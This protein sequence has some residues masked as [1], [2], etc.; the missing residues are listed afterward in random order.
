MKRIQ[1]FEASRHTRRA[2]EARKRKRG[3]AMISALILLSAL[4]MFGLSMLSASVGGSKVVTTQSDDHRLTS[5]VESVGALAAQDVWAGYVRAQGGAAGNIESLRTYL[6]S[7]GLDPDTNAG[8][9]AAG[10]GSEWL[11][12]LSIPT[13]AAGASVF[14]GVTIDGVRV[15]RRDETDAT[16]LYVTVQATT[17]RGQGLATPAFARS[18]Q[19]VYTVEPAPFEGF[20]YGI[21]ANNVNCVFCHTVIDSAE[22]VWS[23]DP[24]Q[25]DTFH[26]VK[27]G[28]LESLM[29]RHDG[30]PAIGDWDSDTRIAGSL[31]VRGNATNQN[32]VPIS[33][34]AS[35]SSKPCTFDAAGNIVQ[36]DY[37]GVQWQNFQP[38]GD[39]PEAGENLYLN[40]PSNY[41]DMVD[42]NLPTEFPPPFR[43]DGGIDPVS[44]TPTTDGAGNRQVDPAEFY[45]QAREAEGTISSGVITVND[46]SDPI[47]T[48]EEYQAAFFTGNHT[49]LGS[50]TT[51]HVI[52]NGTR[53]N[54]IV[55]DG[56]VAIDGD[57]IVNGYVKGSGTLLVSGNIYVPSDLQYLD[58]QVVLASDDP[59]HPT[60][61]R[62]FGVAQDGTRNVL[63]LASGGNV[64]IGDYLMPSPSLAPGA[65]DIVTGNPDSPW[66]FPLAEVSLFNR[67]E[68]ARTQAFLPG[69]GD[70]VRDPSTWT[71]A[72]PGYIEG[73]VPRYYQFGP[74]DTIPIYN[75]GEIYFDASTGTWIGDAE[76]PLGWNPDQ[77]TMVDPSDATNPILYD[78]ATGEPRATVLTLTPSS[79]WITD[80]L[81]ERAIEVFKGE[82]PAN[83]P[84]QIDGLLY[85]NNAIFGI[86]P[87]NSPMKGRLEVNG[88]LVCADL[89]LLAPGKRAAAG[90]PPANL[91][92]GS[93][94]QVGLRVN[95]D[96]RTKKM[97]NIDNPNQV[98]MKRTLWNPTA[99]TL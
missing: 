94:Y 8:A 58:G 30:R 41:S 16:R 54:P 61:P 45:A 49:T 68:W 3:S 5:A 96:K 14:D 90:T 28:T 64:L 67:G 6:D 25:F 10:A 97:L 36:D 85:T 86:V 76:V 75:L 91:V 31:Y 60:G 48:D 71:V 7:I 63:G 92:P 93:P 79:G 56:T 39:P 52:L 2:I 43:D 69:P 9:P 44:H 66:N 38:A 11:T 15:L 42:G 34:W 65:T 83:T 81:Q 4:T 40:Y 47:D 82:H 33:N 22:R 18:V 95:Y 50:N 1:T 27:V 78:P 77:I 53:A 80:E 88:A 35:Q 70:D 20:D 55:I 37:G 72:N 99:N 62:T 17:R 24:T 12:R 29:L 23:Q 84:V 57:V 46:G 98:V 89:G 32:G 26:K 19:L 21:L 51:G 13:D 59:A 73:Y 87:R 74:G